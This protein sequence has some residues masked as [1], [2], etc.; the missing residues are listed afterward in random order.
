MKYLSRC[1]LLTGCLA[2]LVAG[3]RP[4]GAGKSGPATVSPPGTVA[5][6]PP[7]RSIAPPADVALATAPA[8]GSTEDELRL[9]LRRDTLAE[10]DRAFTVLLPDLVAR[11]PALAGHLALAW[12]PGALHDELL[13]QVISRW[14]A[15]DLGGVVT[16]VTSLLD[17]SDRRVAALAATAQ[18]AQD[19]PA[20]AIELA[21]LL[22]VGVD[23]G[24][25]EH[26]AQVWTEE[27]PRAA[28]DWIAHRPSDPVRDRLLARIA[29]A[30]AQ[31]DPTEAAGLVLTQLPPGD[32]RDEALIG[33]VRQWA[34]RDPAPASAWVAQF[35]AGP[36]H[37]RA[38][39]V[40]DAATRLR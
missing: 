15:T 38:L 34:G 11:D 30:R 9:A 22:H 16:W 4:A 13:R 32:S 39:G 10:R 6:V 25:L 19:D 2:A 37:T 27:N 7:L 21:Q 18:V 1:L 8:R 5:T 40:I 23:D 3:L 20:G 31:T 17:E 29:W 36:L 26:L 28:V 14:A 35:P 24:S 12:E 33:V